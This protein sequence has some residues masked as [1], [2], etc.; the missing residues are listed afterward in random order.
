[1]ENNGSV[2]ALGTFDG[3]HIGHIALIDKARELAAQAKLSMLIYTFEN[4]PLE[5]FARTPKLLMTHQERLLALKARGGD[6]CT[7]ATDRFTREYA[8]TEPEVFAR[9]LV[10]RFC[11]K[12]I[13]VGYNHTFGKGGKGT[14]ELLCELGAQLGFEVSI[15][16]PVLYLGEPVS[17][18][19]I[20]AALEGGDIKNAN[21]MLGAP[22]A[23]CG[24]I[25]HDKGIGTKIGFPTANLVFEEY[26]QLPLSG[27][28]AT[29]ATVNGET[30]AGVTNV[31]TN[32]TV[33]GER[34]SV[35]TH[36][37]DFSR[38]IYGE[39][40]RVEF[41]ERLRSEIKFKSTAALA[42]QIA[43]DCA[44]AKLIN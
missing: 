43:D 19:R 13:V 17:S 23:L 44:Q 40:F 7:V 31:G 29:R 26:K 14:P 37:I 41:L 2:L 9:M 39:A 5:I 20:R 4:H 11:A 27:V 10:D 6:G 42:E 30:Y 8:A 34:T 35:E 21:A 15:V 36:M 28:Y 16:K 25:R 3:V 1:M 18:T 24:K 38:D 33:N 32:P 22:Y 12:H